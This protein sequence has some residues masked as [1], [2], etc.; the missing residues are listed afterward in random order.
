M[1]SRFSTR[2][3]NPDFHEFVT[4][5]T[6]LGAIVRCSNR[7]ILCEYLTKTFICEVQPVRVDESVF[8]RIEIEVSKI[9]D[10]HTDARLMLERNDKVQSLLRK[11]MDVF[12]KYDGDIGGWDMIERRIKLLTTVPSDRKKRKIPPAFQG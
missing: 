7:M 8:E 5:G 2:P 6:E 10:V 3:E 12:S 9:E 4:S 11:H 1:R